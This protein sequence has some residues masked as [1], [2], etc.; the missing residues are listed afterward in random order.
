MNNL[1]NHNVTFSK[2]NKFEWLYEAM[3]DAYDFS[4]GFTKGLFVTDE[5]KDFVKKH[6][7]E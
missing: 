7:N 6:N 4:K 3:P 2:D 5:L 1:Y